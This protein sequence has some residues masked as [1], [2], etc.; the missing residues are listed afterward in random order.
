MTFLYEYVCGN[1]RVWG[2]RH[3]DEARIIHIGKIRRPRRST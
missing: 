3:L 1:H 2:A